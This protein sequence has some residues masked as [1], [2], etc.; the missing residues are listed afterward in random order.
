M[1]CLSP[2][3]AIAEG[4]IEPPFNPPG[5]ATVAVIAIP[6]IAKVGAIRTLWSILCP[7][8]EAFVSPAGILLEKLLFSLPSFQDLD[9]VLGFHESL[10]VCGAYLRW[11]Q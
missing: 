10:H 7:T 9:G 11:R 6:A 3:E 8:V 2:L 4:G 5:S 1:R